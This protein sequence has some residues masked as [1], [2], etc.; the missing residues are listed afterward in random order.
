MLGLDLPPGVIGLTD[1][2]KLTVVASL[3]AESQIL[4]PSLSF[5]KYKTKVV[6]TTKR[7]KGTI[8]KI[9]VGIQT[10][11]AQTALI[12]LGAWIALLRITLEATNESNR[13]IERTT[14]NKS[15]ALR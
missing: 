2:I 10:I 7:R 14:T 6:L 15:T 3:I 8:M 4:S 12:Y 1:D 5:A 11:H 9:K 13:C